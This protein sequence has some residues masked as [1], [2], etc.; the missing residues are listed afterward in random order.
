GGGGGQPGGGAGVG[1]IDALAGGGGGGLAG[2]V[3]VA[4]GGEG[5]GGGARGGGPGGPGW[6]PCPPSRGRGGGPGR[7]S[8]GRRGGGGGGGGQAGDAEGEIDVGGADHKHSW[9]VL[10]PSGLGKNRCGILHAIP[11]RFDRTNPV[12]AVRRNHPCRADPPSAISPREGRS[13]AS[14]RG[15]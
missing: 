4:D 8:P 13:I 6:G 11:A 15:S 3:G 7:A 14:T 5:S 1:G 10:L 2:G 9:H 12:P